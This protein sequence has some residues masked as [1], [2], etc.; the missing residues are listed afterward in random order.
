[1]I[2]RLVENH[3]LVIP[4]APGLGES[5]AVPRLNAYSFADW[6]VALLGLTCDE[7]PT[8]VAHSLLGTLAADF[9]SRHGELLRQLLIYAAPGIG[10]YRMPIGLRVVAIRFALRPSA[11]NM[12]RFGR[13]A[14]VDLDRVRGR[15]P[16]WFDAFSTYTRARAA[17]PHIKRTMRQL[18][19][20]CT[21]QIPDSEL[22]RIKA[23]TTLL[24]GDHDRFVPVSLAQQA[25]TRLDWQLH[26]IDDAG[27][28]PHIE[29]PAAFVSVLDEVTRTQS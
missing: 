16:D 14:F 18:I 13:W 11:A 28:V 24:W 20:T 7:P 4:D 8:L 12:E 6:L 26:M 2:S 22:Q 5:D 21:K 25:S 29:Q 1:V 27:H 3:R 17:S 19:G 23:P 9:S 10:P 15:N